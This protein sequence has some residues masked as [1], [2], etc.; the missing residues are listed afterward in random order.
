MTVTVFTARSLNLRCPCPC[1]C[2]CPP[3]PCGNRHELH[4]KPSARMHKIHVNARTWPIL[5]C[6]PTARNPPA[7]NL[8]R[9]LASRG[10]RGPT[11]SAGPQTCMLAFPADQVA[12]SHQCGVG[13]HCFYRIRV[14]SEHGARRRPRQGPLTL[15]RRPGRRA[16]QHRR[17]RAGAHACESLS[18]VRWDPVGR[19]RFCARRTPAP[20]RARVVDVVR[21]VKCHELRLLA[22]AS[23]PIATWPW[24]AATWASRFSTVTDWGVPNFWATSSTWA[25]SRV[26]MCTL[27]RLSSPTTTSDSPSG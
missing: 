15:D 24:R 10:S 18:P 27:A 19:R 14:R 3:Q 25:V 9:R 1:P 4:L 11:S 17:G 21:P 20:H 13:T 6:L 22:Q 5:A 8:T 2:P 26:W 7:R 12:G 16:R 23:R